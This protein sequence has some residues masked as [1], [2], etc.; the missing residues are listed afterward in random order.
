MKRVGDF[1]CAGND[2][3]GHAGEPPH[4]CADEQDDDD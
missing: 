2:E 4:T 3:S 1:A